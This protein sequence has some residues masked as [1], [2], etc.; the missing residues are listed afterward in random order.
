MQSKEKIG[1]G[2]RITL[3]ISGL[4][5]IGIEVTVDFDVFRNHKQAIVVRNKNAKSNILIMATPMPLIGYYAI[6]IGSDG[7]AKG[8][9]L[10]IHG[11]SIVYIC[12]DNSDDV[13][14][15]IKILKDHGIKKL[16]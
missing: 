11:H 7:T 13:N 4:K 15:F 8:V 12:G 1:S 6:I 3:N 5:K 10:K 2:S 14:G 16:N 9:M